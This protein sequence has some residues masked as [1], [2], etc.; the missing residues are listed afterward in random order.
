VNKEV[1][2]T[3]SSSFNIFFIASKSS[4]LYAS[5]T[6]SRIS[7]SREEYSVVYFGFLFEQIVL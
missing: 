4:K 7:G 1:K 6:S 2:T 3:L 5:K